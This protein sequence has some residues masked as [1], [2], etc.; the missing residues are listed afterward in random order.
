MQPIDI[1][2]RLKLEYPECTFKEVYSGKTNDYYYYVSIENK[3][4][5][6]LVFKDNYISLIIPNTP[7]SVH[8]AGTVWKKLTELYNQALS[9]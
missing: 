8:G 2:V 4:I 6:T 1:C 5:A 7:D 9:K 3:L